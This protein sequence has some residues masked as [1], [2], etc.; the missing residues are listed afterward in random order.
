MSRIEN[1]LKKAT[2]VREGRTAAP[3]QDPDAAADLALSPAGSQQRDTVMVLLIA[4]QERLHHLFSA[5][6]PTTLNLRITSNLAEGLQQVAAAPPDFL[7][8]QNRLSGLSGEI[9]VR[10]LKLELGNRQATLVLFGEGAVGALK[11]SKLIDR[12]LDL[13]MADAKL[14]AEVQKILAVAPLPG[15][16]PDATTAAAA[17][18][19]LPAA[20]TTLRADTVSLQGQ[21]PTPA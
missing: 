13:G 3:A 16:S 19:E 15:P 2:E 18:A 6:A 10:H 7:F 1:I 5:A 14:W 21:A 20:D 17:D 4:D 11:S 9:L 8:V 12:Y